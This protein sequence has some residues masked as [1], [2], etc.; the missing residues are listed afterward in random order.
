MHCQH[1]CL[2]SRAIPDTTSYKQGEHHLESR[3]LWSIA[4][5]EQAHSL[6]REPAII[7]LSRRRETGAIELCDALLNSQNVED[8]FVAVHALVAMDTPDAIERLILLYANSKNWKRRYVFMS[9]G[10]VLTLEFIRPFRQMAKDFLMAEMLDVTGWTR[11]AIFAMKSICDCYGI[12]ILERMQ[13]S[14][15]AAHRQLPETENTVVIQKA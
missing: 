5:N 2:I 6:L 10:R 12:R 4:K 1:L 15:Q 11:T 3:R 9:I 13:P 7:E 14:C 8:W